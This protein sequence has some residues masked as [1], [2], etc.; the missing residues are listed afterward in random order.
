VR[1]AREHD[2]LISVR[3]GGHSAA[4][5]AVCENGLMIDLSPMKGIEIDAIGRTARAQ[6]GL[7]LG[8]FDQKTQTFGLAT[9]LGIA[10]DTGIAGLTLGG[11]YG[12]LNGKYGFACDN[13]VAVEVVTADGQRV[14]ANAEENSDLFWTFAVR[15][16]ILG[17]SP[18]SSTNCILS[19]Q[20]SAASFYT[21]SLRGR[22]RCDFSMSSQLRVPMRSAR[23]GLLLSAPDGSPAI[24]IAACY[25]GPVAEGERIL[26]PLRT[27]GSP[28]ADL[29]APRRYTEMQSLFD[30]NWVPG[31][32]NYRKT[33]LIRAPSKEGIEVLL[34]Y[35][36]KTA[37]SNLS[38]MVSAGARCNKPSEAQRYR[39]R[40]PI[41][42]LRRWTVGD[43]ARSGGH[44]AVHPLGTGMLGCAQAVLRTQCVR[45]CRGRRDQRRRRPGKVGIWYQFRALDLIEESVRPNKS[46]PSQRKYP[47]ERPRWIKAQYLG[48][49][50][51]IQD[52][53]SL[54]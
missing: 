43:L 9:T 37:N 20:W 33:S 26:K 13:V 2:L 8:E 52:V 30:Q 35:A 49:W 22:R 28:L 12:W 4:G 41:L 31:Q 53:G 1:F 18:P 7:R 32:L 21:P 44:R 3:G 19:V 38:H 42:S 25:T 10:S 39:L 51:G 11:G 16:R 47:T 46:V 54:A 5:R 45:Q 23:V 50:V 29:I 34:E 24:G 15:V 48:A 40:S 27:F 6:P 17:S 14:S 36:Q